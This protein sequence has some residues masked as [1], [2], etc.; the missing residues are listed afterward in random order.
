MTVTRNC[1]QGIF[2]WIFD[3][4]VDSKSRLIQRAPQI[5]RC[6]GTVGTPALAVFEQFARRWE[7]FHFVSE[8]ETLAHTEI[9]RWQHIDPAKL[10]HEEHLDRPRPDAA[11]AGQPFDDDVILHPGN[12]ARGWHDALQRFGG[13]V[14]DR[15]G[16]RAR[17]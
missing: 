9:S 12:G 15:G 4:E 13:N 1:Q 2:G 3:E 7:T 14:F 10:E 16:F 5:P 8:G 17:Q 11:D 6:D